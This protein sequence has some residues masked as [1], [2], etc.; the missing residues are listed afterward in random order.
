MSYRQIKQEIYDIIESLSGDDPVENYLLAKVSYNIKLIM[1]H[2][3]PI[4]CKDARIFPYSSLSYDKNI[5]SI[6]IRFNFYMP[7]NSEKYI[8]IVISWKKLII[9]PIGTY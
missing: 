3:Q 6:N 1:K 9:S 4:I 8:D 2:L 5:P 7:D